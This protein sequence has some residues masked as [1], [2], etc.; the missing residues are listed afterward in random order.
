MRAVQEKRHRETK[1]GEGSGTETQ[2]NPEREK[3]FEAETR[4]SH[5]HANP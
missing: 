1:R 4:V 2:L 5:V 3:G